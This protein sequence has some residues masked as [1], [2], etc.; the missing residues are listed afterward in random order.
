MPPTSARG[1]GKVVGG[2]PVVATVAVMGWRGA[3]T[4]P[5]GTSSVN[6]FHPLDGAT[7]LREEGWPD[8]VCGL[9]AHHSGSRFVARIRGL[10]G[11]LLEFEFVEDAPSDVLTAA[12]NTASQDGSLV[13]ISGRLREKLQRHGPNWSGARANPQR[14]DYIRAAAR[15]VAQRLTSMGRADAY[16][17]V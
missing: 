13:T 15:R 4:P 14:D 10:D 16:L 11:P 6:D 17:N 9:V 3:R 5:T 2:F 1:I 7:Y 12:D 8:P